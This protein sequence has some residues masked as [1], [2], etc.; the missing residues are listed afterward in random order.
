MQQYGDAIARRLA[1]N[2]TIAS[3]PKYD[4]TTPTQMNQRW[5]ACVEE[6]AIINGWNEHRKFLADKRALMGA[7][8]RWYDSQEG[9]RSWESLHAGLFRAFGRQTKFS[10]IHE[11]LRNRKR[12]KDETVIEFDHEM[13]FIAFQD[14]LTPGVVREYTAAEFT[15]DVHARASLAIASTREQFMSLLEF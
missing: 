1:L 4:A 13:E 9:V 14:N 7:A 10:D 3:L 6:D 8:K 15:D 2:L 11:I 12:K 5:I